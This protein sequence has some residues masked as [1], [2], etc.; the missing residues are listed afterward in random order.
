MD[1][2]PRDERRGDVPLSVAILTQCDMSGE[3]PALYID[4]RRNF[5][6]VAQRPTFLHEPGDSG[7]TLQLFPRFILENNAR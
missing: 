3:Y 4:C 6:S 1:C 7:E 2:V 5:G